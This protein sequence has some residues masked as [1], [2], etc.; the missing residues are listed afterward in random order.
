[1]PL[2]HRKGRLTLPQAKN[3]APGMPD[4][5]GRLEYQLLHHRL[6]APALGAV[7]HRRIGLVQSVLSNQTQQVHRHCGLA[8]VGKCDLR[9]I[10]GAAIETLILVAT[11]ASLAVLAL[12]W[13]NPAVLRLL[14]VQL[15][16]N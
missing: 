14:N 2:K 11:P 12:L 5:A 16:K 10:W 3:P 9:W 7:A 6:D 4:H 15:R 8:C 13:K 1:M